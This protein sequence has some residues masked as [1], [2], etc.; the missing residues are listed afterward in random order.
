MNFHKILLKFTKI[1]MD[2]QLTNFFGEFYMIFFLS[3]MG[4]ITPL[5]PKKEKK[6]SKYIFLLIVCE[7]V[8]HDDVKF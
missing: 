4:I 2:F 3:V 8:V 7:G 1:R 5:P 6:G